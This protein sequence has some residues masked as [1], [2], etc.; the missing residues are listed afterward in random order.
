MNET[1]NTG[2]EPQ[3]LESDKIVALISE[4]KRLYTKN[5]DLNAKIEQMEKTN[6]DLN[7]KIEQMEKTNKDL[8]GVIAYYANPNTPPSAAS[9]EWKK[10][11][12]ERREE[13]RE[14]KTPAKKRGARSGHTGTSRR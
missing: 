12:R 13:K 8:K 10:E 3:V 6:K 9:L 14:G 1:G 2:G 7:A 4:N 11:K 5:E